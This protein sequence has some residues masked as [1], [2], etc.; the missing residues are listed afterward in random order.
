MIKAYFKPI[1]DKTKLKPNECRVKEDFQHSENQ[2]FKKGEVFEFTKEPNGH[3]RITSRNRFDINGN[4]NYEDKF[5]FGKE[6][7]GG[8]AS[9]EITPPRTSES[10]R[11]IK[12]DY[13]FT[14]GKIYENQPQEVE[15][16]IKSGEYPNCKLAM[17]DDHN[18]LYKI[19][20]EETLKCFKKL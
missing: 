7:G 17:I 4:I 6:E 3:K 19:A 1:E 9:V 14:A 11:C 16:M 10:Y 2:K 13:G 18:I 12:S 20:L 8:I 5:E 15:R